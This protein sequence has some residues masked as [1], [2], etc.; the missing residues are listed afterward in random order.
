[1]L[2]NVSAPWSPL[3]VVHVGGVRI[4][5]GTAATNGPFVIPQ[6]VYGCG[7]PRWNNTVRGIQE[8]VCP[9]ATL[10]TNPI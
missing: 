8:K 10:S 3:V 1:M 9:I 6:M 2:L 4:F 7:G 5:L